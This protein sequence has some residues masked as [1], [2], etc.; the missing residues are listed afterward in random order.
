MRGKAISGTPPRAFLRKQ[1]RG[2]TIAGQIPVVPEVEEFQL[3]QANEAL[4][5]L[6]HARIRAAAVLKV[7]Q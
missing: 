1:E 2:L 5:S 7:Q 4:I 3:E 6:K